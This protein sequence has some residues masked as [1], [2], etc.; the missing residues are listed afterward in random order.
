VNDN[1]EKK[2]KLSKIKMLYDREA[3]DVLNNSDWAK[4]VSIYKLLLP[5]FPQNFTAILNQSELLEYRYAWK[6]GNDNYVF[7]QL[8]IL[9]S[10]KNCI[11]D[12]KLIKNENKM[13]KCEF[14]INE[15]CYSNDLEENL[16]K[17]IS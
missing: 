17:K 2:Q 5:Y 11:K 14:E 4:S 10:I 12:L 9:Y 6:G 16:F 3:A 15:E 8:D 13:Y 7:N 1:I